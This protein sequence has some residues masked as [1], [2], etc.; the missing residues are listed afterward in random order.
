[1][2]VKI[3][4]AGL[5]IVVAVG[6]GAVSF[7][8]TNVQ[9]TNFQ[10]AQANH[11]KVQVKGELVRDKESSYDASKNEFTFYMKDENGTE[12]KVIFDGVKPNN[13]ELANALVIKGTYQDKCFRASEILTKCPSKYEAEENSGKG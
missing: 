9:Y 2:N 11:K 13:F 12:T 7:V 4:V 10:T 3:I 6:F 1:M 8:E 5:L